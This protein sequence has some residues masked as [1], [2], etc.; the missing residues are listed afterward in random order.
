MSFLNKILHS[1]LPKIIGSRLPIYSLFRNS[2]DNVV[3]VARLLSTSA[4]KPVVTAQNDKIPQHNDDNKICTCYK[5]RI[6]TCDK[7]KMCTCDKPPPP[8]HNDNNRDDYTDVK[9]FSIIIVLLL[10]LNHSINSR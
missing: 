6:C 8:R 7:S 10:M 5:I 3:Y 1:Q 2:Q 4:K 9:I